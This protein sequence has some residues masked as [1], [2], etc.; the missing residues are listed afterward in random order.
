MPLVVDRIFSDDFV[1]NNGLDLCLLEEIVSAVSYKTYVF[2]DTMSTSFETGLFSNHFVK[3]NVTVFLENG[4][5]NRPNN[6]IGEFIKKSNPSIC[7]YSG[8]RD[9]QGYISFSNPK[10]LP[11]E[12][13]TEIDSDIEKAP[14]LPTNIVFRHFD[15]RPLEFG[16]FGWLFD[17]DEKLIFSCSIKTLFYY[18]GYL[19]KNM[20]NKAV[21]ICLEKMKN[22]LFSLFLSTFGDHTFVTKTALAFPDVDLAVPG[23]ETL[24]LAT[25]I[26]CMFTQIASLSD[27]KKNVM[28]VIW[29]DR[30]YSTPS[31]TINVDLLSLLSDSPD[32][33]GKML[34]HYRKKPNDF[35]LK[36]VLIMRGKRR[37]I[38]TYSLNK[39][40]RDLRKYHES[41]VSVFSCYFH[42]SKYSYSYTKNR[43]IKKCLAQHLT[44][45]SFEKIDIH[46]FFDSIRFKACSKLLI[47][48]IKGLN[49][50]SPI[51]FGNGYEIRSIFGGCFYHNSLPI[52]FCSSP[53]LS[54]FF[55][56]FFDC[57]IGKL[58]DENGVIY[59]RYADDIL[60][61]AP[62]TNEHFLPKILDE[63][64]QL[65][66]ERGLDINQKKRLST[67]LVNEGSSIKFLGVTIVRDFGKKN[68]IVIS[69]GQLIGISKLFSSAIQHCNQKLGDKAFSKA[70]Y[71]RTISN[72]SFLRLEKLVKIKTGYNFDDI[73]RIL[74][75]Q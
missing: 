34:L 38:V 48:G 74:L 39:N 46:H 59:T 53:F 3:D 63:T 17:K 36:R 14:S 8:N 27:G 25:H 51:K 72:E 44:S 20:E 26:F 58:A 23:F 75:S 4:Y 71:V 55:M 33:L 24:K 52:G 30:M 21:K 69:R 49:G 42:S 64:V 12:I 7:I 35:V 43:N 5:E 65:L 56:S 9:N 73:K 16:E 32:K 1:R 40:G 6:R 10:N 57:R 19:S 61:S 50:A 2:L 45:S 18:L 62:E 47:N 41:I 37:N 70:Q 31:V 54:E 11:K 28:S 60:F 13:Q 67:K 68:R 22:D 29:D 15:N 66:A